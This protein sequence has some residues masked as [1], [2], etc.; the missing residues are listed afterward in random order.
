[1]TASN[2]IELHVT[3]V[4]DRLRADE[5]ITKQLFEGDVT[6]DPDLYWNV[7]HDTGYWDFHSMEGSQTDV[8][9]TFTV[10]SVGIERW[11]AAWGSGRV[12]AQLLNFVPT[13]PGRTCWRIRAAGSSPIQRD[14]DG[15]VPRFLAVDRFTLRSTPA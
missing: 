1:M 2:L 4:L 8:T 5:E 11:Q 9:V 14:D 15:E 10:H 3:A 6:G 13:I 12:T 7:F